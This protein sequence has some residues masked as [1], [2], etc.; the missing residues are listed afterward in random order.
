MDNPSLNY[1]YWIIGILV[2]LNISAIGSTLYAA[3]KLVWYFAKLDSR[4][5]SVEV[6]HKKDLNSAHEKIRALEKKVLKL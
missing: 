4:V 6:N 2:V 3:I 5:E 1:F